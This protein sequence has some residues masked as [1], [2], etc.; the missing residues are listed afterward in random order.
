M[1]SHTL[2][3]NGYNYTLTAKG[4][5]RLPDELWPRHSTGIDGNLVRTGLEKI[6]DVLQ[7][8]DPAS[9]GQWHKD[10]VRGARHDVQDNLSFLMGGSDIQKT[11]LVGPLLIVE[12][13]NLHRVSRVPQSYKIDPL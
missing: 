8:I 2:G 1:V 9:N 6:A 3:V 11:E 7:S 12:P 13:G 10:L 5:C 4:F